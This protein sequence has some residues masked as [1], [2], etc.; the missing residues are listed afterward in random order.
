MIV[1]AQRED[2]SAVI[3][4]L[5]A[6]STS[7]R[8]ARCASSS[9]LRPGGTGRQTCA[10][11]ARR[12]RPRCPA[13]ASSTVSSSGVV[14]SRVVIAAPDGPGTGFT[15]RRWILEVHLVDLDRQIGGFFE[16]LLDLG[17]GPGPV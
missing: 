12:R 15:P 10:R 7:R 9:R 13:T 6:L 4:C 3:V 16:E 17:P 5:R 14:R 11:S 8:A 2:D 1:P